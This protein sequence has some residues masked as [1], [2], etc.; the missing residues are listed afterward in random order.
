[1]KKKLTVA[2]S[3]LGV[4]LISLPLLVAFEAHVINVTAQIANGILTVPTEITYGTVFPQ[5]KIDKTF[6]ILL[7]ESFL[8]EPVGEQCASSV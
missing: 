3:A 8:E 2:I 5:E 4:G 6:Q 1:M 7:S